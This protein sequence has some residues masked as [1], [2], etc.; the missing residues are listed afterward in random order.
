[1]SIDT[2]PQPTDDFSREPLIQAR[3]LVAFWYALWGSCERLNDVPLDPRWLDSW[4]D[5][6]AIFELVDHGAD[7]RTH[8]MGSELE[9]FLGGVGAGTMLSEFPLPYRQRLRQILLRAVVIRAPSAQ[10]YNWLVGGHVRSCIACAMPVAGGFYQPSRLL[11]A[12]F[13]RTL[14][15]RRM[16]AA[17]YLEP[18]VAALEPVLVTNSR[19]LPQS[20]SHSLPVETL[21]LDGGSITGSAVVSSVSNVLRIPET[22]SVPPLEALPWARRVST[23][24]R[25]A[26]SRSAVP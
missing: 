13:R 11:L 21:H 12:I 7:F 18:I 2:N 3:E 1:V 5:D 16:E 4:A 8:Q 15:F 19:I 23:G 25:A 22:A 14:E 6:I 17:D 10:C 9:A 24:G 20:V 26:P